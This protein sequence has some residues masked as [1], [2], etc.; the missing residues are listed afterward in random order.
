MPVTKSS[1]QS[2]V[3]RAAI[4][5]APE[6]Y[7]HEPIVYPLDPASGPVGAIC[8]VSN[9]PTPVVSFGTSYSG[10]NPHGPDENIR[11]DD[12]LQAI[13][14]FGRVIHH[15]GQHGHKHK[16]NRALQMVTLGRN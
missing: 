11:I 2:I 7:G 4:E 16:T 10:S 12:Y 13:K 14:F 6:I 8:G 1:P 15:L 5:S 3:A 9:P